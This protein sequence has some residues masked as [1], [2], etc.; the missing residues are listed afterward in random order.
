MPKKLLVVLLCATAQILLAQGTASIS[1]T[2]LDPSGASIAGATITVRNTATGL[3][4]NLTTDSQGH[5]LVPDTPV[6]R[7]VL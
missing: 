7:G 4:R 3:S 5:Y 6:P 1:A 2:V